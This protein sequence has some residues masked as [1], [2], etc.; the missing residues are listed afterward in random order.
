MKLRLNN[1]GKISSA[2]GMIA[3]IC[4]MIQKICYNITIKPLLERK[5]K[6]ASH[7][8]C[9]SNTKRKGTDVY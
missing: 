2:I 4:T 8:R 1:I 7:I 5:I 6:N 3:D 9:L